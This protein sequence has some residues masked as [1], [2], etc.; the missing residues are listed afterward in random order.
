[1]C[2]SVCLHACV[3]NPA[4]PHE[5]V[6]VRERAYTYSPACLQVFKLAMFELGHRQRIMT[7]WSSAEASKDWL[8][9]VVGTIMGMW[10]SMKSSSSAGDTS[11]ILVIRLADF[12]TS[13]M[14]VI[15]AKRA[16]PLLMRGG[17]NL[18]SAG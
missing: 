14:K 2:M 4:H 12:A 8:L 1:M 6:N 9:S 16:R 15:I 7:K 3:G 13:A 17:R 5:H 10:D 11:R 18:C